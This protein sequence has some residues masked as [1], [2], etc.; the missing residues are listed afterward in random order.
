MVRLIFIWV[1]YCSDMADPSAP[2]RAAFGQQGEGPK[3]RQRRED[4]PDLSPPDER[5]V[6]SDEEREDARVNENLDRAARHYDAIRRE[7]AE[8]RR[9]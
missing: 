1:P 6:E 2:G 3:P 4:Q 5:R 9:Q 7:N 8:A